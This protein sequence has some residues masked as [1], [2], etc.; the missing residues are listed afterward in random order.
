MLAQQIE[1]GNAIDFVVVGDAAVAIAEADLGPHVKLDL[2]AARSRAAT[3]G[4]ARRPAIAGKR[5]G[6]FLPRAIPFVLAR[7]GVLVGGSA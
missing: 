7:R 5:P 1:I 6:D 2:A 3:E 4:L